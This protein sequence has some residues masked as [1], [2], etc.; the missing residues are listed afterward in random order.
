MQSLSKDFWVGPVSRQSKSSEPVLARVSL[1][2]L[3]R[4]P[5][6]QHIAKMTVDHFRKEVHNREKELEALEKEVGLAKELKKIAMEGLHL[7]EGHLTTHAKLATVNEALETIPAEGSG[8][9]STA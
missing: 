9:S 1:E 7:A 4:I 3:S 2:V 6:K 5:L 8:W